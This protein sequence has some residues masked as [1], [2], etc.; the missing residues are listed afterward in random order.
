[1]GIVLLAAHFRFPALGVRPM[2]CDEANQAVKTG[3]LYDTGVYRYDPREH[4]GPTL[5]YAA[6]PLIWASGVDSYRESTEIP[7]RLVPVFFG[8]GLVLILWP[9]R[10]T[11]GTWP[12]LW[13]ALFTAVSPAMTYYSRYFIQEM[14]LTFFLF[15]AVA[16]GNRFLRRKSLGSAFLFGAMLGLAHATKET[17]VIA[18]V[19][20]VL[21]LVLTW[22]YTRLKEG[23]GEA[24]E[25]PEDSGKAWRPVLCAAVIAAAFLLVALPLYT[26]FFTYAR[27]PL[28]SVLTYL[29]YF[30]RAGGEGSSALHHKPWY[31]YAHLLLFTYREAGPRWTEALVLF[32]ALFGGISALRRAPRSDEGKEGFARVAFWRFLSFYAVL[33]A[34]FLSALPYKTPWNLLPF[35]Q[36]MIVLAG[37]GA[38]RIAHGLG[39]G[40]SRSWRL[41]CCWGARII[42]GGKANRPISGTR[43]T[44][45]IR[46][47]YAHTSTALLRLVQR[48]ED[49]AEIYPGGR[50]MRV[51]IIAPNGDY[52][53]LP[54]YLRT[55]RQTGY[56][57]SFPEPPDA[58]VVIAPPA[59]HER[60]AGTLHGPYHEEWHALRPGVK[61]VAFIQQDLWDAFIQSRST[62][63][64]PR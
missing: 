20:A 26:S 36:P 53:P 9:L 35:Y 49:L 63:T 47:S 25:A 29:A 38:A 1:M 60:L 57:T 45:G 54:W 7:Y 37:L 5:Y 14:L 39:S 55:F 42:W 59:L 11:L 15:A 41:R 34:V 27:G 32:L 51:Y 6:L 56:F 33:L 24:L 40:R 58:P 48:V 43:R 4:H 16:A 18:L 46:M 19:A 2:H 13:A 3:I 12:A 8:M 17:W 52:W 10:K 31:Y 22:L 62:A 28:D 61:L 21:A 64:S 50:D 30:K 44:R 23:P